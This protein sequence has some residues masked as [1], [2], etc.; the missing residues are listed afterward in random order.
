MHTAA[1]GF[2]VGVT[3]A[4]GLDEL[5]VEAVAARLLSVVKRCALHVTALKSDGLQNTLSILVSRKRP[6]NKGAPRLCLAETRRVAA[7]EGRASKG[8][9]VSV[10]ERGDAFPRRRAP[11]GGLV[12][13]GRGRR[14]VG[15]TL[16][17]PRRRERVWRMLDDE[18]R[19]AYEMGQ[20]AHAPSRK[21]RA[22]V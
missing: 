18:S 16:A 8:G 9:S 17:S 22:V 6:R 12:L 13:D 19:L 14:C 5:L 1:R 3:D 10:Q 7:V 4:G 2:G 20:L 15:V 11:H 21:R